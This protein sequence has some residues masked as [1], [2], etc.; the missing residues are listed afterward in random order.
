MMLE[1]SFLFSYIQKLSMKINNAL[2]YE[3]ENVDL[4]KKSKG[5]I[6]SKI[7]GETFSKEIEAAK[8]SEEE[9]K[10]SIKIAIKN[11][12]GVS[13]SLISASGPFIAVTKRLIHFVEQPSLKILDMVTSVTCEMVDEIVEE[14]VKGGFSLYPDLL[15]EVSHFLRTKIFEFSVNAKKFLKYYFEAQADHINTNHPDFLSAHDYYVIHSNR[16]SQNNSSGKSSV[17]SIENIIHKQGLLFFS[18]QASI[19]SKKEFF[20]VLR[21]Q[22]LTIYKDS[23]KK[24]LH[25]QAILS[26]C[27]IKDASTSQKSQLLIYRKDGVNITKTNKQLELLCENQEKLNLWKIAF[28]NAGLE[29]ECTDYRHSNSMKSQDNDV[30]VELTKQVQYVYFLVS[31]YVDISVKSIKDMVAKVFVSSVILNVIIYPNV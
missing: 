28:I 26:D 31:S 20:F 24:E 1:I 8:P 18:D 17:T 13:K 14:V 9:I 5:T 3:I 25:D 16:Q 4:K 15:N 7:L 19:K 22:S 2:G 27:M 23:M 21:G 6:M 12:K 30:D 29:L 10:V 11:T